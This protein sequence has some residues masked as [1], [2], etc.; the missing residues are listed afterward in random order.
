MEK[1]QD[2][3]TLIWC[4]KKIQDKIDKYTKKTKEEVF[5]R[6]D[7]NKWLT[8]L[9]IDFHKIQEEAN[10]LNLKARLMR[11]WVSMEILKILI[12]EYEKRVHPLI[13]PLIKW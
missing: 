5:E 9:Q 8:P 3:F 11:A 7:L 13:Y 4:S 12:P 6:I 10:A 1:I 2:R